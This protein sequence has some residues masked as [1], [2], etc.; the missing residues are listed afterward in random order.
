MKDFKWVLLAN[1]LSVIVGSTCVLG[2][3]YITK[4]AN[5]LWA[6]II[7][8]GFIQVFEVKDKTD[9]E[10]KDDSDIDQYY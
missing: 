5:C 7:V 1:S 10:C 6:L 3:T 2:A 4:N 9:E 8:L